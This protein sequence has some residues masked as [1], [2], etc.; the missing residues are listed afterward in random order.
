MLT[1]RDII[2][3]YDKKP[4]LKGVS[5]SVDEGE[6][7]GLIGPNG[8][9]K[10]TLL[11]V[12]MGVLC[13]DGGEV[14]FNG[15]TITHLSTPERIKAGI[16]MVPQGSPVFADM[17][18][19]ENLEMGG[20]LVEGSVLGERI[21]RVMELFPI[22]REREGLRAGTLSGGE[23]QMLSLGRALVNEPQLLLL[24]EP[25]MGLDR[26]K[27]ETALKRIREINDELGVAVLMV[28]QRVE[29]VL[30]TCTRLYAMRLGE[31]VEEGPSERFV[32]DDEL[33]RGVF[34]R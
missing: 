7:V 15:E 27:S 14:I 18:V 28:E 30:E 22:L 29:N 33:V 3:G 19:R 21:E 26:A 16:T 8:A 9:G 24:D 11:K 12:I 13:V 10:S 25:S 4:V 32:G 1:V 34:A 5:I 20:Y 6:M 2:A 17:T 23:Q 31:I